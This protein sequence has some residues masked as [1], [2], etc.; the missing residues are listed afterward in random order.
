MP[1]R[2][3]SRGW[4][5]T[6]ASHPDCSLPLP[7][8]PG[9]PPCPGDAQWL[10]LAQSQPLAQWKWRDAERPI[11]G[12]SDRAAARPEKDIPATSAQWPRR[13][14]HASRGRSAARRRLLRL[15]PPSL[16]PRRST[17]N[18]KRKRKERRAG[19]RRQ[20]ARPPMEAANE[21][22]REGRQRKRAAADPHLESAGRRVARQRQ[23]RARGAGRQDARRRDRAIATSPNA[24]C[25]TSS[26]LSAASAWLNLHRPRRL[27]CGSAAP[28]LL[29]ID[30]QRAVDLDTRSCSRST[31]L[32]VPALRPHA[33]PRRDPAVAARFRRPAGADRL[34]PRWRRRADPVPRLVDLAGAG[35]AHHLTFV[36]WL[37][38]RHAPASGALDEANRR[39]CWRRGRTP[40]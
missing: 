27:V 35:Q 5:G 7:S 31:G 3:A 39:R 20:K 40:G 10:A 2:H 34:G 18:S 19:R 25:A 33:H 38:A 4:P 15:A 29:R 9:L 1:L 6:L 23:G 17:L 16:P 21:R 22:R 11:F 26:R 37:S 36:A 28:G 8:Q 32:Q 12:A 14:P 24:A 13:S 30:L